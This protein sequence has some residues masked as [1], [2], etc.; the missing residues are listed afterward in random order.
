[1]A[2]QLNGSSRVVN[3]GVIRGSAGGIV[4]G[5][6]DDQLEM[7]GGSISGGVQ[8]GA[9]NDALVIRDGAIDSVDQGDG[10]DSFEISGG[11]V[12]GTVQQGAGID[13]FLMTGGT[14]GALLQGDALDRFRMTG[15]RIIGAF[16]DGD[17]AE[18]TGGRIGRVNLKLDNN[19]F[20]MSGGSID[21]NLVAG[22][23]ND[24]I[25]LSDGYIGGNISVSG[26]DDA[27]TLTGGTVRGEIRLSF[28]NDRLTWNGGGVVHD[29]ID[30][31]DGND[32]ARLA[33]LNVSH[34]GAVPLFDGGLGTD[35]LGLDN[36]KTNGVARFANW[37]QVDLRNDTQLS[38]DGP[39]T[40]GDSGT[41]TGTFTIDAT[42]AVFG[43]G[44]NGRIAPF[45]SGQLATVSNAG[46]IDL[47]NGGGAGDSFTIVG[48][49][50]GHGGALYLQTVLG[51]DSSVSDKLVISNGS[52]SG[53]T[54]VGILNVGGAGA[55]TVVDGILVVQAINGATTTPT[56]FALYNPVS[57]GAYEYFL[58]KGGV[59]G[60]TGENWYLRSTL[61]ANVTPAPG[62]SPEGGT[63][64]PPPPP[65]GMGTPPPVLPPAPPPPPD[66]NP[67][68]DPDPTAAEPPP[69]P[70]PADPA[71]VAPPV[72]GTPPAVPSGT[73]GLPGPLSVPPTPGARPAQGDIIPLYRFETGLYS[74][75]LPLL[76]DTSLAS[77]RHLPRTPGRTASVGRAGQRARGMGAADRAEPRAALGRRCAAGLRWRPAG[78][79]GRPGPVCQCR[80]QPSR[81]V[82]CLRRPHPRAGQGDRLCHRLGERRGRPHP[83]G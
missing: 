42:S 35:V 8:Q 81:S 15:G 48:N 11:S 66:V 67:P 49:Y 52:A 70:E 32:V 19:T 47:S 23:G 38:F 40:L 20:L 83:A 31:G 5:A 63:T 41:G 45:A 16:D 74:A 10:Q 21:G 82:R 76:R 78:H 29:A 22:F 71:P 55:A 58:F 3:R 6:G 4:S 69:P 25:V 37:E 18:M 54:G 56:A 28:G 51:D 33:N 26:G 2:L 77:N 68:N 65:E 62:P 73:S 1:V 72:T 13:T 34:L 61:A 64:Q 43:G 53:T 36:V 9:D 30:F 17:Y 44:G 46:R 75:L 59:S 60:G 14:L 27:V 57:A 50:V 80:R 79:P 12:T 24:T 39:L 7:L